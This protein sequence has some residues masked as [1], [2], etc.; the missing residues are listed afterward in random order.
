MEQHFDAII[1]GAGAV[2]L[3]TACALGQAGIRVALIDRTQLEPKLSPDYDLRVFA[4][5]RAAKELFQQVQ[6][7]DQITAQRVCAFQKMH[8]WDGEGSGTL[9]FDC[10]DLA[11]PELGHIIEQQ[12][13]QH[14][15]WQRVQQL[16]TVSLLHPLE[17]RSVNLT[18]NHVL[19][20][21]S[22]GY[23]LSADLLIGADGAN[24]WIRKQAGIATTQVDYGQH[25]LVANLRLAQSHQ[26]TAW[27]RFMPDGP[28]AFLPLSDPQ[29]VSIVWSS[30]PKHIDALVSMPTS[31]FEQA[32]S[33][34]MGNRF[35]EITCQSARRQFPL[36]MRHA[37]AY[38]MPH[39]ALIGDAAHTLHPLAGQGLNLGLLDAAALVDEVN[40][41]F[42]TQRN[43]G[44][45]ALLRRYQR[46]RKGHNWAMT[47]A[48]GSF[49]KAFA[50]QNPL[51]RYSRNLG[52]NF[53]NRFQ[54][55]KNRFA[56]FAM[57][58]DW[59]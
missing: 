57:G 17:L 23:T 7:W 40:K 5:T 18:P 33:D 30:K 4:I 20:E 36:V 27:Q 6:V 26:H 9:T 45:H 34:A 13:I 51:I 19:L 37:Q 42:Q 28:L 49:N 15:L 50:S 59:L 46:R 11:E 52:L 22:T 39:L 21:A 29:M 2:G 56:K 14:A 3:F 47:V 43:I 32:C 55:V 25:A 31:Q 1:V 35:T 24:S 41:A 48:V 53:S 10:R 12:V 8:I 54:P 44:S 58:V 38:V 16:E